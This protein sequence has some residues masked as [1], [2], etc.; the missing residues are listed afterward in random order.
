[1]IDLTTS[2]PATQAACQR[3]TEWLQ[4]VKA[5]PTQVK[6]EREAVAAAPAPAAAVEQ[7]VPPQSAASIWQWQSYPPL[8][9]LQPELPRGRFTA[10]MRSFPVGQ[11]PAPACYGRENSPLQRPVMP[12]ASP[13]TV[14]EQLRSTKAVPSH[15]KNQLARERSRLATSSLASTDADAQADAIDSSDEEGAHKQ[16]L[17][18][19]P[20]PP[21]SRPPPG[22]K[23][24]N[25]PET[26][27]RA[28]WN[29]RFNTELNNVFSNELAGPAPPPLAGTSVQMLAGLF[30]S[31]SRPI[32]ILRWKQSAA[33]ASI[34]IGLSRS[35]QSAN[36]ATHL[37]R[38]DRA[39]PLCLSQRSLI[40][41]CCLC[42]VCVVSV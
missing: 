19:V 37:R 42:E 17:P 35:L 26:V 22:P 16:K 25:V 27:T 33:R 6:P 11:H 5:E 36:L 18:A 38:R 12:H 28:F 3:R 23:E 31:R 24:P 15:Q 39:P 41:P 9:P 34:S 21:T 2:D 14:T 32:L 13:R 4:K 20:K 10:A 40:S 8:Q 29:K 7:C 30:Y 1:M